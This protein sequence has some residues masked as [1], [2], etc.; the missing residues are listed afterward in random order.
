M[1]RTKKLSI[2]VIVLVVSCPDQAP[3]GHCV[4]QVS[5]EIPPPPPPLPPPPPARDVTR[6]V[7]VSLCSTSLIWPLH[8]SPFSLLARPSVLYSCFSTGSALFRLLSTF[9]WIYIVC[10]LYFLN[11][12]QSVSFTKPVTH[13]ANR[14]KPS[15]PIVMKMSKP[16]GKKDTIFKLSASVLLN[17]VRRVSRPTLC[18]MDDCQPLTTSSWWYNQLLPIVK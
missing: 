3:K 13:V 9:S 12:L 5:L 16:R 14:R 8:L 11:V 15:F 2:S 7:T 10:L 18:K 17:V 1:K 4:S 6:V